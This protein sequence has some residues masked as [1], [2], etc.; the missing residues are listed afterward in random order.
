MDKGEAIN[1]AKDVERATWLE[2][3]AALRR[4]AEAA[5]SSTTKRTLRAVAFRFETKA[6]LV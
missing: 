5:V 6:R 4:E 2:A 1:W 3:A